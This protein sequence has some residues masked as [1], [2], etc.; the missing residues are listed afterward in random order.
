MKNKYLIISPILA[1]LLVSCDI[2]LGSFTPENSEPTSEDKSETSSTDKNSETTSEVDS[3]VPSVNDPSNDSDKEGFVLAWSDEFEGTKLNT[4][5]WTPELGDHG[6]GNQENQMYTGRE[7]NVYVENGN[8]VI[9]VIKEKY[10]AAR[11][12]EYTSARIKTAG[13]ITTKYG[14]IEARIS[15]PAVEG[16]WP[17][18]WMMPEDSVYGMWPNSGEI[19]IMEVR[20]RITDRTTS[21]LHYGG[22][23]QANG[24]NSTYKAAT[25]IYEDGTTIEDFHTYGVLWEED[26]IEW[27]VDG[28][29]FFRMRSG[30][31]GGWWT[32]TSDRENAPFDQEFYIILNM[33][34]GGHFD[35]FRYPPEGFTDDQM[36]VDY[37]R[38]YDFA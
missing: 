34:V 17:A 15:L 31:R 19:D 22:T 8:L 35:E 23:E 14:Y 20:G 10:N 5:Y 4:K 9:N 32:A 38:I 3:Q 36:L 1:L 30:P 24:G 28:N 25:Y 16:L 7:E 26:Q 37:V 11:P 29:S 21:A 13:K 27:F 12:S 18:F 33:A 2:S 6:W